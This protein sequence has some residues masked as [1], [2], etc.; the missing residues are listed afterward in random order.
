MSKTLKQSRPA[1][2]GLKRRQPRSAT[3]PS[4]EQNGSTPS[5][6]RDL[7]KRHDEPDSRLHPLTAL[8]GIYGLFVARVITQDAFFLG[9]Q[10]CQSMH[11][12]KTDRTTLTGLVAQNQLVTLNDALYAGPLTEDMS[13]YVKALQDLH[14]H[15]GLLNNIVE[16][17]NTVGELVNHF[18]V[19]HGLVAG[20]HYDFN[21]PIY[22]QM[23]SVTKH[24]FLQ[25]LGRMA[26]ANVEH[27]FGLEIRS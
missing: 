1:V 20:V 19:D 27:C 2:T 9:A 15:G 3:V 24:E 6:E 26:A 22:Y 23:I 25:R 12:T 7:E 21:T 10:V 4:T 17:Q 8:V 14:F 18:T 11:A 5:Y 16:P 13:A